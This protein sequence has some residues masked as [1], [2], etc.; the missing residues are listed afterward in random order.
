MAPAG[1]N[2]K[3]W[4]LSKQRATRYLARFM[5]ENEKMIL[6]NIHLEILYK[7]IGQYLHDDITKKGKK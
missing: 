2:K 1:I 6:S 5:A 3:R 7:R 4:E